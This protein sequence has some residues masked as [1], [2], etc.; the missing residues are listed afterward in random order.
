MKDNHK[1]RENK[2]LSWDQKLM[3]EFPILYKY[4]FGQFGF[5]CNEGWA[6]PIRRMSAKLETLNLLFYSKYRIRIQVD[7]LKEKYGTLRCYTSVVQDP[8]IICQWMSNII[9]RIWK[10]FQYN[11][12]YGWKEIEDHPTYEKTEIKE[13]KDKIE[14]LKEQRAAKNISNVT[15]EEKNGKYIKTTVL[16][17]YRRTHQEPSRH[18]I[19]WKLTSWLNRLSYSFMVIPDMS[20][21]QEVIYNYMFDEATKI[22]KDAEAECYNICEKCGHQI[23]TNWSPRCE[24]TGWITYICDD[25]AKNGKTRYYKN[26][27][28]YMGSE[29]LKTKAEID[30][31]REAREAKYRKRQEEY[32]KENTEFEQ[33]LKTLEKE[34][35]EKRG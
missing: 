10:L 16:Q 15:V 33:Q 12:D 1:D 24:T 13:L 9:N 14:F 32:E 27:A 19:I 28:L 8:N 6:E 4:L 31:E 35:T 25:C 3:S 21:K 20:W 5:E 26:G 11:V 17:Y 22:V 34:E 23:G 7:Q 30:A 2:Q 18:R 29:L